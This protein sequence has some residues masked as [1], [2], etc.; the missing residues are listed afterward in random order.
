M[1][2]VVVCGG[3]GGGGGGGRGL[4]YCAQASRAL[5]KCCDNHKKSQCVHELDLYSFHFSPTIIAMASI[6]GPLA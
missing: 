1:V 4:E 2:V 5:T 3:G 6:A